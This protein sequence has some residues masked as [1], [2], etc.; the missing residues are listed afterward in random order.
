MRP[1][2]VFCILALS[3][4]FSGETLAQESDIDSGQQYP[5]RQGEQDQP[6]QRGQRGQKRQQGQKSQRRQ[7]GQR[8]Q[9]RQGQGGDRAANFA[10]MLERMDRNGDD[11]ISKDEMPKRM[12][13]RF[14]SMDKNGDGVLDEAEQSVM[15]E[16][17]RKMRG[18]QKQGQGP[19]GQQAAGPEGR[20]R[21][22]NFPQLLEKMDKNADG[23]L[24]KDELPERM[25]RRFESMDTNGNGVFD[26]DEQA[27]V[28][29]RMQQRGDKGAKR[30]RGAD[31]K[32]KQ[33]VKPKRP[34]DDG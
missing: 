5:S 9:N 3:V 4:W 23:K 6:G 13:A 24:T 25:Q 16:R 30:K 2:T 32:D 15:L 17:I 8:G 7:K 34:G 11:S 33:G 1:T 21:G 31:P 14:E 20:R 19:K 18:R 26:K 28:I 12:Q 27:V 22:A 10:Q 29:E